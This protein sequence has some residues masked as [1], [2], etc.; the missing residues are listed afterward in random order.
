MTDR[1]DHATITLEAAPSP[2]KVLSVE[3]HWVAIAS[4]EDLVVGLSGQRWPLADVRLVEVTD[5]AAYAEGA[6]EIRRMMA[7]GVPQVTAIG[8]NRGCE[9]EGSGTA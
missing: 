9:S 2:V 4:V 5:F 6:A 8:M 3:D 1:W 7:Y